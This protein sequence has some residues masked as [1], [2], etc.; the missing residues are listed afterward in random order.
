MI[1]IQE[2]RV[3]L[4]NFSAWRGDNRGLGAPRQVAAER[5]HHNTIAVEDSFRNDFA[6]FDLMF[7][8]PSLGYGKFRAGTIECL[9][10]VW[11]ASDTVKYRQY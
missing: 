1:T 3:W 6:L 5:Q 4:R 10:L 11:N 8:R 7:S 9:R 2:N